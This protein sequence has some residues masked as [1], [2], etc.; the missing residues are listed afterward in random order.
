M[1]KAYTNIPYMMQKMDRINQLSRAMGGG[2]CPFVP[3]NRL[4]CPKTHPW[5]AGI[6]GPT[7]TSNPFCAAMLNEFKR[8][9]GFRT[10]PAK[11]NA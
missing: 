1:Y 4:K 11:Y 3:L 10:R 5:D 6:D 2:K 7:C 8:T 9:V